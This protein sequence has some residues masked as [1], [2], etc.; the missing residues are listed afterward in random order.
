[1]KK[2]DLVQNP[3]NSRPFVVL[4][5]GRASRATFQNGETSGNQVAT[6]E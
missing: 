3:E 5:G 4:L 1:M 6:Y 2:E